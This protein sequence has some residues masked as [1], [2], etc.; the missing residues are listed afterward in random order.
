MAVLL[1]FS[2]EG[3]KELNFALSDLVSQAR[4]ASAPSA[5]KRFSLIPQ[6]VDDSKYEIRRESISGED[7]FRITGSKPERWV[8]QTDFGNSEAVG[9]LAERLQKLGVEDELLK[10][11]AVGGSTVIIGS[12]NGVVFDW[13]PLIDSVAEIIEEFR[14]DTRADGTQRRT[15]EE[16]RREYYEMMDQRA[17]GRLEREAVRE[18]SVFQEDDEQ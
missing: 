12:G 4:K 1:D 8:A 14:G 15:N 2:R 9:Y 3:L 5:T 11:G 7:V 10:A 6:K 16:R 13:Q 18:A 17:K